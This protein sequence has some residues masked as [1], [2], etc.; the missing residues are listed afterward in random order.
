MSATV[1]VSHRMVL[2][3]VSLYAACAVTVQ[4]LEQELADLRAAVVCAK[5]SKQAQEEH[6]LRQIIKVGLPDTM[7]SDQFVFRVVALARKHHEFEIKPA[8]K[9]LR[10]GQGRDSKQA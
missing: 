3:C 5:D 2:S 10:T 1:T 6:Y 9:W 4:Q 7:P 8:C